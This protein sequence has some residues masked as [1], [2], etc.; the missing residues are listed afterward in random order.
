MTLALTNQVHT[1]TCIVLHSSHMMFAMP[2]RRPP[3]PVHNGTFVCFRIPIPQL[4]RRRPISRPSADRAYS[5]TSECRQLA[6]QTPSNL[7][8][9]R[10]S[11]PVISLSPRPLPV[12][13]SF[14]SPDAGAWALTYSVD[15]T[16]VWWAA[17]E[18][19]PRSRLVSSLWQGGRH[20]PITQPCPNRRP[21]KSTVSR[22]RVAL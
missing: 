10:I 20:T 5:P 3:P 17:T 8:T 12:S 11:H 2:L 1:H 16:E 15:R 7:H 18:A 6:R 22:T 14:T 19:A 9:S 21:N 13:G 4:P